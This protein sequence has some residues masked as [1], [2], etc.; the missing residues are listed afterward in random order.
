MSKRCLI[1]GGNGFVG[2]AIV[3]EAES[4]GYE[5]L[6]ATS[7]TYLDFKGVQVDLLINA[8]GNSKKFL[9]TINLYFSYCLTS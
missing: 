6:S 2:S 3:L 4:R 5:T 7:D 9:A 1:L 8:N